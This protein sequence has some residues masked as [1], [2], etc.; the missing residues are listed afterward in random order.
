MRSAFLSHNYFPLSSRTSHCFSSFHKMKKLFA[1]RTTAE[2]PAATP[3]AQDDAWGDD[4]AAAPTPTPSI[5][6]SGLARAAAV[7]LAEVPPAIAVAAALPQ[8]LPSH[9]PAAAPPPSRPQPAPLPVPGAASS[10]DV[11]PPLP[12]V[13]D[14]TPPVPLSLY[15]PDDPATGNGIAKTTTGSAT[16]VKDE[17]K[18]DDE[19][20]V[21]GMTEEERHEYEAWAAEMGPNVPIAGESRG[22]GGALKQEEGGTATARKPKAV[23]PTPTTTAYTLFQQ[24]QRLGSIQAVTLV[25]ERHLEANAARPPH[26]SWIGVAKFVLRC[27]E[28]S[29]DITAAADLM[30]EQLKKIEE[31]RGLPEGAAAPPGPECVTRVALDAAEY[32]A[33]SPK[34]HAILA[35][36]SELYDDFPEGSERDV[37]RLYLF[38]ALLNVAELD[39]ATLLAL[40]STRQPY[41]Y[42]HE[43]G[44][45]KRLSPPDAVAK[46]ESAEAAVVFVHDKE[47]QD[48]AAVAGDLLALVAKAAVSAP[49][50]ETS[51][52]TF[53]VP[54]SAV[55]REDSSIPPELEREVFE[56]LREREAVDLH[57]AVAYG[58]EMLLRNVPSEAAPVAGAETSTATDGAGR[59]DSRVMS[60]RQ[61]ARALVL[62]EAVGDV[63]ERERRNR[64]ATHAGD[65]AATT[66]AFSRAAAA[67][68]SITAAAASAFP[69][70]ELLI[71]LQ[72]DDMDGAV[73]GTM[74]GA[75]GQIEIERC[76]V[77][78]AFLH[79]MGTS[80]RERMWQAEKER[81][82]RQW[83]AE[84]AANQQTQQGRGLG[85][86][87][88]TLSGRGRGL[89]T[90]GAGAA[91]AATG[92]GGVGGRGGT[93]ADVVAAASNTFAGQL[94]AAKAEAQ[95]RLHQQR[96]EAM[97]ASI[98]PGGAVNTMLLAL[99]RREQH[100]RDA[101]HAER[102]AADDSTR[103]G[104]Y[105]DAAPRILPE[106]TA[107]AT[108][109]LGE[110][111]TE[112]GSSL[113]LPSWLRQ[114]GHSRQPTIPMPQLP[115]GIPLWRPRE[116]QNQQRN[117]QQRAAR[118][119]E[120]T[121]FI[122]YHQ[123]QPGFVPHPGMMEEIRS[124]QHAQQWYASVL[125]A[126]S[127][128]WEQM[129]AYEKEQAEIAAA[130]SGRGAGIPPSTAAA[131]ARAAELA[132]ARAALPVAQR[133]RD[134][135]ESVYENRVTILVAE[136][137]SGKTTQ[138]PQF[139][140]KAGFHLPQTL[141]SKAL[142]TGKSKHLL[143]ACTQP[144][145][146]AAKTIAARVSEEFGAERVGD[147]VGYTVRF[148]DMTSPLTIIK[149]MTDGVL[150][151]EALVDPGFSRYGVIILDEAHERNL[152]TDILF[153]LCKEALVRNPL[154]RLVVTSA[155]LDVAKFQKYFS[156]FT[157]VVAVPKKMNVIEDAA[158]V[159]PDAPHQ[160]PTANVVR[161]SGKTYPVDVRYLDE[162]CEDY[163]ESALEVIMHIHHA[164]PPGDILV[165]FTGRD[166]IENARK[167]LDK[168]V[169][170]AEARG[171][172]AC[173]LLVRRL[174]AAMP[175]EEKEKTLE[176]TP[177]GSRK[178]VLSTNIAETSV[179]ID[180]LYYVVDA[181]FCK[182]NIYNPKSRV[183]TLAVIPISQAQADQRKGRAGR[184]GPGRC[185]RLY[186]EVQFLRE[187]NPAS[188]PE[189]QRTNLCN[190]VL[191]LKAIGIRDL[192]AFDFMDPPPRDALIS[193][194]E[195]LFFLGALD[196]DAT[197]TSLGSRM[198]QLPISPNESKVLLTAQSFGCL[199]PALVIV[200]MLGEQ[201]VFFTPRGEQREEAERA[202]A[203][204]TAV[205]GDMFTLLRVYEEWRANG[206]STEWCRRNFV[207]AQALS[208]ARELGRQLSDILV[209]D[210]SKAKG[211]RLHGVAADSVEERK[212]WGGLLASFGEKDPVASH[213]RERPHRRGVRADV[214]TEG[215]NHDVT[216]DG[217]LRSKRL[218]E[219]DLT[220]VRKAIVAGYFVNA[221]KRAGDD[222]GS[223][224][225]SRGAT[226]RPPPP[227]TYTS[228]MDKRELSLHPTSALFPHPPRYI[229]YHDLLET[230]RE[231]MRMVMSVD[232]MWLVEMA[233]TFYRTP[234]A[235][236]LTEEM[237]RAKV[238]PLLRPWESHGG[239]ATWRISK[240][241]KAKNVN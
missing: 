189:V 62:H 153:A 179:T 206:R 220:P 146:I 8:V 127:Q 182:E 149:Y 136:T 201:S 84:R 202:H 9:L 31:R 174:Y 152:N 232:P 209:K 19:A 187:L 166:E 55:L 34:D 157:G 158:P 77:D 6:V 238:D 71:A 86:R 35:R 235:G 163:F 104:G 4:A 204:F 145:L 224:T 94:L 21:H 30:H 70:T 82:Q 57:Y 221:A 210:T 45:A 183:D 180:D 128:Y 134:I 115:E 215:E 212:E 114:S 236:K 198:S 32:V 33:A 69:E 172:M 13:V 148:D 47:F 133:E 60:S 139:L 170:E 168:W 29:K 144:R 102:R 216:A 241:R 89:S 16:A 12:R 120:L 48:Q 208:R 106:S 223:G 11:A 160:N 7:T 76:A 24:L 108:R 233:P 72:N 95:Q 2:A 52:L 59:S 234:G 173:P 110:S 119:N 116:A 227:G 143:I 154:L 178:V 27:F 99:A 175:D 92:R 140:V 81:R 93:A 17:R 211:S 61:L 105:G 161:V 51:A 185:Y 20:F 164:E 197:L 83:A 130:G 124:V 190:V 222:A 150:L 231:Y 135:V 100:A 184:T 142:V 36:V 214:E 22:R 14:A 225:R 26:A 122:E 73:G 131:A 165:F 111:V 18:D 147:E 123:Q 101:R 37:R 229:L 230:S 68:R 46:Y 67:D 156:E 176:K 159:N 213:P 79:A 155:T 177:L 132:P 107:S 188:T 74:A 10:S 3:M 53:H 239:L 78:P 141:N 56:L 217:P 44:W 5:G 226:N 193:A 88:G 87:P 228:L 75:G 151:R 195:H 23:P 137:G 117:A 97:S 54:P 205:E 39:T 121:Q 65:A 169:A 200:A 66:S 192:L 162:P 125:L 1:K 109:E 186:T 49:I 199:A 129:A 15:Q 138:V 42:V 41:R 237:K 85:Y 112:S 181:G 194:M 43:I 90:G 218:Y 196:G 25:L 91:L 167:R 113:I 191:T 96:L 64:G 63:R 28:A 58:R 40:L 171:E 80:S 38:S 126:Q 203:R 98:R 50:G 219:H 118:L 207:N 240:L 103:S